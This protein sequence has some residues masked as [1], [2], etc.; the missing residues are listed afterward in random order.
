MQTNMANLDEI[1]DAHLSS[2][3]FIAILIEYSIDHGMKALLF[4]GV[5]L[6]PF[7]VAPSFRYSPIQ[8]KQIVIVNC[9]HSSS[10]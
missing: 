2:D 10:H 5:I 1:P 7:S 9:Q 8:F 6:I 4:G 3:A